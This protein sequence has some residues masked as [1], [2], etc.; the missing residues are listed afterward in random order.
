MGLWTRSAGGSFV[1]FPPMAKGGGRDEATE[2]RLASRELGRA[3]RTIGAIR[4]FYVANA[5]LWGVPLVFVLLFSGNIVAKAVFGAGFALMVV[6]AS[7]VREQPFAWSILIASIW[8]VAV[9]GWVA[10]GATLMSINF[11]LAAGWTLGCWM[12][13][14]TTVRVNKLLEQYPDLWISKKM[15]PGGRLRRSGKRR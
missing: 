4:S 1:P 15:R 9:V 8:T 3:K 11:L 5:I 14:P 6:G 10:L 13:L 2:R 12:M 7:K